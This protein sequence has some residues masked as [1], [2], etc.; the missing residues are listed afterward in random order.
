MSAPTL[1]F[2]PPLPPR[3]PWL[4]R[5]HLLLRASHRSPE[6]A[7]HSPE[8]TQH[9]GAGRR[10]DG[11]G[12]P[13]TVQAEPCVSGLGRRL[14]WAFLP[15]RQLLFRAPQVRLWSEGDKGLA[16]SAPPSVW[17]PGEGGGPMGAARSALCGHLWPGA[18]PVGEL[19]QAAP[20]ESGPSFLPAGARGPHPPTGSASLGPLPPAWARQPSSPSQNQAPVSRGFSLPGLTCVLTCRL[21]S[22]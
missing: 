11:A 22:P 1:C 6:R 9:A 14:G 20:R 19:E 13:G 16:G 3:G 17:T 4:T 10:A 5:R 21:Q 15:P 2:L 18:V 12:E 7:R 8:A